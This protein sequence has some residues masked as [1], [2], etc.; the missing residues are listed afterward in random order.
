V[1]ASAWN[2]SRW[3]PEAGQLPQLFASPDC[4]VFPR[5]AWATKQD[6]V[7]KLKKL[8]P[9]SESKPKETTFTSWVSGK[10]GGVW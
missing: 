10:E 1:V 8:S 6:L 2:P 7:S 9:R 4:I 5:T 3:E